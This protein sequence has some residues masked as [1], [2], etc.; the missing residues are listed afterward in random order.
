MTRFLKF[1]CEYDNYYKFLNFDT[2]EFVEVWPDSM[3]LYYN[4]RE[5]QIIFSKNYYPSYYKKYR[6]NPEALLK[7][8]IIYKDFIIKKK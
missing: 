6:Y 5:Y 7:E 4:D 2:L 1:K 3:N 8:E